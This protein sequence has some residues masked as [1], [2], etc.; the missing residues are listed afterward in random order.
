MR[1][2]WPEILGQSFATF[3]GQPLFQVFSYIKWTLPPG[4]NILTTNSSPS[5]K[6]SSKAQT[7]TYQMSMCSVIGPWQTKF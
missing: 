4:P 1:A 7:H 3:L 2:C 6:L 5:E